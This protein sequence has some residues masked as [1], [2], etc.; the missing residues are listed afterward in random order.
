[1]NLIKI[2]L[3]NILFCFFN[4][5]KAFGSLSVKY[6]ADIFSSLILDLLYHLDNCLPL[7]SIFQKCTLWDNNPHNN[8]LKNSVYQ[9]S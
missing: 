5:S 1:M 8:L 7:L 4:I 3:N 9:F 2:F 6:F